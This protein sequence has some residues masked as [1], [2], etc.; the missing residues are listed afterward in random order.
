MIFWT[1]FTQK[2]RFQFKTEK[3]NAT[4]EFYILELV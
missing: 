2:G 1:K 3:V 4:T